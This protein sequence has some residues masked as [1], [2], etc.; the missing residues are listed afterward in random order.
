MDPLNP[1]EI[2]L[3]NTIIL[4]S[5]GATVTD[6]HHSLIQGNRKGVLLGIILT[7][8]LA[9]ISTGPQGLE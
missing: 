2:P 4:L 1:F 8:V 7:V 9:G 6:A 5:S 3:L